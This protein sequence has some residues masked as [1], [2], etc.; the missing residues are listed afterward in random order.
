MAEATRKLFISYSTEDSTF[1]DSLM[2]ELDEHSVP[3]WSNR[4]IQPGLRWFEQIESAIKGASVLV[5]VISPGFQASESALL[6]AGVAVGCAQESGALVVPIVLRDAAL[7]PL[8]RGYQALH[9]ESM[10]AEEIAAQL[11]TLATNVHKKTARSFK[12][13]H[14]F[15]SS[16]GDV[17]AERECVSRVLDELN[18]SVGAAEGVKLRRFTWESSLMPIGGER[19]Q[20]AINQTL[21]DIDVFLMILG[22]SLGTG[23]PGSG[24]GTEEE[25]QTIRK[26]WELFGR[27][28]I[29]CYVK[30]A[31]VKLE[32]IEQLEQF[33]RVLEFRDRLKSGGLVH[34]F[35]S[36]DDLE[37]AVRIHFKN[38]IVSAAVR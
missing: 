28:Q 1:V 22:A 29:L 14:L 2:R 18:A 37:R 26:S 10:T 5:L 16:S 24:S 27:P 21:Q 6:E 15:V 20:A 31:P 8:F 38:V 3:Y 9:A 7:P 17:L 35:E 11:K 13:L 25:F 19:S 36:L 23:R 30:T 34:E 33:R 12:E 4:N 32:S